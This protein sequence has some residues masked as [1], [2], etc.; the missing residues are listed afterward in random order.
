MQG[1]LARKFRACCHSDDDLYEVGR[2]SG[3]QL[4][5]TVRSDMQMGRWGSPDGRI[6][7][8]NRGLWYCPTLPFFRCLQDLLRYCGRCVLCDCVGPLI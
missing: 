4:Y 1:S 5:T 2:A 3:K 8:E 7:S 6:V